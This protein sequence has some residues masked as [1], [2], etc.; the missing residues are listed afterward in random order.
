MCVPLVPIHAT[1]S[2]FTRRW[3]SLVEEVVVVVVVVL[4]GIVVVVEV[5]LAVLTV[6]VL[7]CFPFL[8]N[9]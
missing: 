5:V 4:A 9:K 1:P 2:G 6:V 7:A 8:Y 3:T